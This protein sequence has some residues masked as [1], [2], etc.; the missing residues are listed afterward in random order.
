[1]IEIKVKLLNKGAS[2]PV[3]AHKTDAG[4]DLF[5]IDETSINRYERKLIHTGIS[6]QIPPG[7]YGQI[8]DRSG[9]AL[10][11]GLHIMGGVIDSGYTGEVGV[12]L[13]NTEQPQRLRYMDKIA[14]IVIL[15]VPECAIVPVYDELDESD[16]GDGGFGSTDQ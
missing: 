8:F 11:R 6:I 13:F 7:Y 5:S 3:K 14:Q 9:N 2:Y 10:K 1:M 4:F 15:P 16:R 12:I